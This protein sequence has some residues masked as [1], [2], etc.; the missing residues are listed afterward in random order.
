MI[1]EELAQRIL[2]YY[3]WTR[4]SARN[5][6]EQHSF[7]APNW[8]RNMTILIWDHPWSDRQLELRGPHVE[9]NLI[10]AMSDRCGQMI[11]TEVERGQLQPSISTEEHLLVLLRLVITS[12]QR[13]NAIRLSSID[14]NLRELD[15]IK[16]PHDS[17]SILNLESAQDSS[18]MLQGAFTL[19]Q[20]FH[21]ERQCH[22]FRLRRR[23][24]RAFDST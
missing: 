2:M 13:F 14:R 18:L 23:C 19:V 21:Q 7:K 12:L 11:D 5:S 1:L 15:T 16:F 8:K 20:R 10:H 6:A 24:L 9:R 22:H 17:L 4:R 3:R